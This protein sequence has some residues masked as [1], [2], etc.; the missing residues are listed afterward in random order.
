MKL[1]GA[2][3]ITLITA[4]ALAGC[5]SDNDGTA[6]AD[7]GTTP[8]VATPAKAPAAAEPIPVTIGQPFLISSS[9]GTTAL[10]NIEQIQVN[11][12][13]IPL[14]GSTQATPP[15]GTNVAILF[16]VQ[17]NVNAPTT[18]ISEHW[19]HELTPDGYTKKVEAGDTLCIH[20]RDLITSSPFLPNSK[21]KG[22]LLL[23]VSNPASSLLMSDIWDGR[24][25]P[26][27]HR[28][29]LS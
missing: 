23:D 5:S 8:G 20:D 9:K 6:R 26:E 13:C 10:V 18:Y 21:Y 17:T 11:P 25:T 7:T 15:A 24:P 3:A 22:W 2:A 1:A 4:A 14:K 27:V 28:I 29:P 12:T 16:D 19:F